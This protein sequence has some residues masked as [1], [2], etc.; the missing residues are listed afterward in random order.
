VRPSRHASAEAKPSYRVSRCSTWRLLQHATT[1]STSDCCRPGCTCTSCSDVR[2]GS[3]PEPGNTCCHET[4]PAAPSAAVMLQLQSSRCCSMLLATRLPGLRVILL[5]FSTCS[6]V[7][8]ARKD[9][10]MVPLCPSTTSKCCRPGSCTGGDPGDRFLRVSTRNC[11][12]TLSCES[13]LSAAG[14]ALKTCSCCSAVS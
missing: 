11:E 6:C 5:S 4:G 14:V 10:G 1:S 12:S 2:C 9:M 13:V 7:Q 8:L 3:R